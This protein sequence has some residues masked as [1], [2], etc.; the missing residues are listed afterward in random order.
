MAAG[1][2]VRHPEPGGLPGARAAGGLLHC[3]GISP[4]QVGPFTTSA[5]YRSGRRETPVATSP[6]ACMQTVAIV[7]V[8]ISIF[9]WCFVCFT[10]RRDGLLACSY[11]Y[12]GEVFQAACSQV[13]VTSALEVSVCRFS[14]ELT[15]LIEEGLLPLV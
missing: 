7:L 4:L 9:I 10:M 15:K 2:G 12:T 14:E 6:C 5:V 11:T 3:Y 13:R 8:E 1:G